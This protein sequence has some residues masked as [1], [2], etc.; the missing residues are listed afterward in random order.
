MDALQQTIKD[1]CIEKRLAK[2]KNY[3]AEDVIRH[4]I[5]NYPNDDT[6]WEDWNFDLMDKNG[7]EVSLMSFVKKD[8]Y[9]AYNL[10]T[11]FMDNPN[12]YENGNLSARNH[13]DWVIWEPYEYEDDEGLKRL[14]DDLFTSQ[15]ASWTERLKDE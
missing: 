9:H 10:Y 1:A 7:G 6:D 13:L 2:L 15:L 4:F 14:M 8:D 12:K 5:C 3:I 11:L